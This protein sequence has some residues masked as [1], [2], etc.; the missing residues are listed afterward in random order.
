MLHPITPNETAAAV[1]S[2][3]DLD[4]VLTTLSPTP[5]KGEDHELICPSAAHFK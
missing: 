4:F 1:T 2:S 3:G 5:G